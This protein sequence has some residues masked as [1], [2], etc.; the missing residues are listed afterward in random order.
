MNKVFYFNRTY[1][2][3]PFKIGGIFTVGEHISNMID[4]DLFLN[5]Y[6]CLR[7]IAVKLNNKN[8]GISAPGFNGKTSLLKKLLRNGAQYIA[9]DY[10]V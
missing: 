7:G 2:N 1:F 5:G 10:L 6:V 8:I 4:L 3:L 9:E